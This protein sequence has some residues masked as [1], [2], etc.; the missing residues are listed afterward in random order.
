MPR[1]KS[2]SDLDDIL[3]R[4]RREMTEAEKKELAD[5]VKAWRGTLSTSRAGQLLGMSG[6]T[7]E[8]IEAGRGF[9]YPLMLTLALK[10]FEWGPSSR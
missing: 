10:S 3:P 6:R 4:K 9:R 7:V 5:M 8:Y 1:K 2:D